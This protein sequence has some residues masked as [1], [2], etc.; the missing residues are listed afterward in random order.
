MHPWK[1]MYN[2]GKK[3]VSAGTRLRNGAREDYQSW[4]QCG[5]EETHLEPLCWPYTTH[6]CTHD[7]VP[8]LKSEALEV[9]E[10]PG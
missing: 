9:W 6:A 8:S 4:R 5:G 7:V 1:K 2:K 3:S 10:P